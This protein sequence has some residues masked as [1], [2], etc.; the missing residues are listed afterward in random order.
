[1]GEEALELV[2]AAVEGE[3]PEIVAE[4][5]DLVFHLTVLLSA[6]GLG[7]D[8]IAAELDRRAGMSGHDE[9]AARPK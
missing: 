6:R 9:K 5:A 1:L 8:A 4:A 2:I 3:E 7:W